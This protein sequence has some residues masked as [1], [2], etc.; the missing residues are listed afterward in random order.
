MH[1]SMV[2]KDRHKLA[3]VYGELIRFR[4]RL[5]QSV[6]VEWNKSISLSKYNNFHGTVC[7]IMQQRH[8]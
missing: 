7:V 8:R 5:I 1:I 6:M 4:V 3:K 2:T